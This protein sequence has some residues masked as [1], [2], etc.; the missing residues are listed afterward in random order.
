MLQHQ[1]SRK[2]A[3]RF[4][5]EEIMGKAPRKR[6]KRDRYFFGEEEM[7]TRESRREE[8]ISLIHQENHESPSC[9]V[10]SSVSSL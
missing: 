9:E 5:Y 2:N 8:E 3:H 7:S 1:M 4:E 6:P 10:V